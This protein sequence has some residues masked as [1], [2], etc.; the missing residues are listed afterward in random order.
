[1]AVEQQNWK[2]TASAEVLDGEKVYHIHP[3]N[4]TNMMILYNYSDAV[5]PIIMLKVSLDKNFLD[6]IIKNAENLEVNLHVTKFTHKLDDSTQTNPEIDFIN[7]TYMISVNSDINYN[8]DL[9]YVTQ[10]TGELPEEDKFKE[11]SIVLMAKANIDANKVVANAVIH[12]SLQQDLV[13]SYLLNN[14]CHLLIEPFHHN[15]MHNN[16]IIPPIDTMTSLIKH[17]NSIQ[18]FYDSKYILFFDEPKV[19]YLLS[20]SGKPIPMKGEDHSTVFLNMRGSTEEKNL[21]MGMKDNKDAGSYELEVSVLN[22]D[23]KIDKDT[24]KMVEAISAIVNPSLEKSIISGDIVKNLKSNIKNVMKSF[25]LS[26]LQ[27]ALA[28][29]GIGSKICDMI[30]SVKHA[31]DAIQKVSMNL[32]SKVGEKVSQ[33]ASTC[34]KAV[35]S[36]AATVQGECNKIL[37]SLPADV[38]E[39]SAKSIQKSMMDSRFISVD[40]DRDEQKKV[41]SDFSETLD[42]TASEEYKKDFIDNNVSSVTYILMQEVTGNVTGAINKLSQGARDVVTNM[43][44]KVTSKIGSFTNFAAKNLETSLQLKGWKKKLLEKA[45]SAAGSAAQNLASSATGQILKKIT[46]QEKNLHK[47]VDVANKFGNVVTN[48]IKKAENVASS[49]SQA[50]SKFSSFL[51][52][53]D[54]IKDQDALSHFVSKIPTRVFGNKTLALDQFDIQLTTGGCFGGGGNAGLANTWNK[55]SSSISG[56]LNFSDLANLATNVMKKNLSEI[57]SLGLSSFNF[58]LNLGKVGNKIGQIVGTKL[59]KIKN[60]NPNIVKNI[61]SE[62]ELTRNSLTIHKEGL[63]PDVFTP[64][65]EYVIKNYSGHENKDGKFILLKKALMFVREDTKF[66]C[67][68]FLYFSKLPDE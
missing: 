1:M 8:K 42:Q 10:Q 37:E 63:D 24:G 39:N 60:D 16:L 66:K 22:S 52:S 49:L 21:E 33:F 5:M 41:K 64:N 62:V 43:Q 35:A 25:L 50:A 67:N 27:E 19:T 28:T 56:S 65:K 55:L 53:F 26:A 36:Q 11:T 45:T 18:V 30:G 31:V 14:G 40:L 17:L 13:M 12:Q 51:G 7:G 38:M 20:K 4:I 6:F 23:Y 15:E 57:G 3:E 44:S 9:D 48:N 47:I 59:L 58:D 68:T 61:K 34:T 2:F 29:T 32:V 54:K 46:E